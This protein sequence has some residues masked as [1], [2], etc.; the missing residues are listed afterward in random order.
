MSRAHPEA[1]AHGDPEIVVEPQPNTVPVAEED[2]GEKLA[3]E[4]I[5][6]P[7]GPKDTI[8]LVVLA[9]YEGHFAR[10]EYEGYIISCDIYPCQSQEEVAAVRY[11]GAR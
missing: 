5:E 1:E 4:P 6:F 10:Y 9:L 11:R 7:G 8:V 3:E 2:D